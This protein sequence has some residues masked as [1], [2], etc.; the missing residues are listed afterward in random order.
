M[1]T[2]GILG[3]GFGLYGYLPAVIESGN[4][5]SVPTRYKD[6]IFSRF[7]LSTYASQISYVDE[8]EILLGCENLVLA[9]DPQSQY[10]FLMSAD[11]VGKNLWL[12]KPLA[13]SIEMHRES[14]EL[15]SRKGYKF[16]LGYLFQYTD[17]WSF[18]VNATSEPSNLSIQVDW[19]LPR[20]QGWKDDSWN[21]GGIVAFYAIHFVP[22]LLH[23]GW[24]LG[25]THFANLGE[26]VYF[27]LNHIHGM[28]LSVRISY[29]GTHLFRV[30]MSNLEVT[31]VN[32][33]LGK[34]PFGQ[35]PVKGKPDP[36]LP[37]LIKYI[38]QE[39]RPSDQTLI[40]LQLE[41]M[42]VI[43]RKSFL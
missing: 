23:E 37:F 42:A 14:I 15:I 36:R 25:K 1:S 16:S 20:P 41:E 21:G 19:D 35:L 6:K 24:V 22:L 17:W 39:S 30:S 8:S 38:K 10:D 12:E 4:S 3:S 29:T 18:L 28:K 31:S 13:P 7:E 33:F 43:F 11:L 32:V 27:T 5:V 40:H 26:G 9:R 2:F 34:T